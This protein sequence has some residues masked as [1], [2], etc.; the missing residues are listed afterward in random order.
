[1]IYEDGDEEE[2]LDEDIQSFLVHK[3]SKNS[4]QIEGPGGLGV[5]P[6][7]IMSSSACKTARAAKSHFNDSAVVAHAPFLVIQPVKDAVRSS[8]GLNETAPKEIKFES[9]GGYWAKAGL[10]RRRRPKRASSPIFNTGAVMVAESKLPKAEN[11][12]SAATPVFKTVMKMEV[13]P[14]TTQIELKPTVL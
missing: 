14:S 2:I 11:A 13:S 8:N 12:V 9:A 7:I 6:A 3:S 5:P 1:V 10:K 4:H